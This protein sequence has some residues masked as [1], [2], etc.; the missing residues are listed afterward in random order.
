MNTY[1]IYQKSKYCVQYC[2]IMQSTELDLPFPA[3]IVNITGNWTPLAWIEH[4]T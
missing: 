1:Y 2:P 4:A 3:T